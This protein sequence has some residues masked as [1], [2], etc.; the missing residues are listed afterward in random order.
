MP[1]KYGLTIRIDFAMEGW[2]H[3]STLESKIETPN[4]REKRSKSHLYPR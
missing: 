3:S 2:Y 4:S 1:F